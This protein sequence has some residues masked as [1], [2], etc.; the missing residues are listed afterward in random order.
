MRNTYRMGGLLVLLAPLLGCSSA[1]DPPDLGPDGSAIGTAGAAGTIGTGDSGAHGGAGGNGTG[2]IG[3]AGAAGTIGT[4][5]S[6]AYGGAGGNGTG[7]IGIAGSAAS[8][9]ADAGTSCSDYNSAVSNPAT[10]ALA[11]K[12]A[13][14]LRPC[15]ATLSEYLNQ[16]QALGM[17]G[18]QQQLV[19]GCGTRSVGS[20]PGLSGSVYTY[21]SNDQLIGYTIWNDYPYGPCSA[22]RYSAGTGR[23]TLLKASSSCASDKVCV[24]SSVADAASLHCPAR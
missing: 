12:A 22:L 3:T 10:L 23:T 13:W 19:E 24:L 18:V 14:Y 6:G 21:D 9:K 11:C 2:T 8:A 5:D 7:T 20:D 16:L 1:T 15:G 4:G 17:T